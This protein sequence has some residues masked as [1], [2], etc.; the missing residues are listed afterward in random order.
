[1]LGQGQD[2]VY[3]Y[4][5]LASDILTHELRPASICILRNAGPGRESSKALTSIHVLNTFLAIGI[6][7][8][9][10]IVP[11][12]SIQALSADVA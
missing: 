2:Y 9:F 3:Y 1:M 5:W 11:C 8:D 10:V 7:L 12:E 6:F 4:S